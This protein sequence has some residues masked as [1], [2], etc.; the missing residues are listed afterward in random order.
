LA[1][2]YRFCY[3]LV[4]NRFDSVDSCYFLSYKYSSICS[5]LFVIET[6]TRTL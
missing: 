2:L 4:W 6:F 5:W 3:H 1:I